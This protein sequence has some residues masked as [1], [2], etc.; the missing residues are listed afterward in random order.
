MG[1]AGKV[2]LL[3]AKVRYEEV[4]TPG[5][6]RVRVRG[7]TGGEMDAYRAACRVK[8]EFV[9]DAARL[10]VAGAVDGAGAPLFD[11]D[12]LKAVRALP[13]EITEPIANVIGRLSGIG[14]DAAKNS[15]PT[16][17]N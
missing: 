2:D 15:V 11:A 8:G 6:Q 10:V 12:D 14:E 7:L 13:N 4:D 3:K 17:G 5:G 16:P 1:L 9:Y